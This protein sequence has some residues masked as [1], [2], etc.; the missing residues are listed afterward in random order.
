MRRDR[1]AIRQRH[2]R[3]AGRMRYEGR[4]AALGRQA[5]ERESGGAGGQM[6]AVVTRSGGVTDG[7]V[8]G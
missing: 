2:G 5:A 4:H 1:H 3:G 8:R 7:A 6:N